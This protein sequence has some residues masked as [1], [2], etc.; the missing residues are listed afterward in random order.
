MQTNITNDLLGKQIVAQRLELIR[1]KF[2]KLRLYFD[3]IHD[4]PQ[5]HVPTCHREIMLL[6]LRT[7]LYHVREVLTC[8][9][10]FTL[11]LAEFRFIEPRPSFG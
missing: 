4:D 6:K 11:S 1:L 8:F 7:K 9:N 3:E 2:Y 5:I 10:D